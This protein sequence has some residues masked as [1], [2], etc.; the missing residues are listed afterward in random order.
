MSAST[1]APQVT[2]GYVITWSLF[3]QND[4]SKPQMIT[5]GNVG[6]NIQTNADQAINP[7]DILNYTHNFAVDSAEN[8]GLIDR[9]ATHDE[10]R[11]FVTIDTMFS[12]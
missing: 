9:G 4:G 2:K 10:S 6:I 5:R 3:Y 1:E 7:I 8:Y 12:V 11:F